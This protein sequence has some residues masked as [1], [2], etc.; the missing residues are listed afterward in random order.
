MD[1]LVLVQV[2]HNYIKWRFGVELKRIGRP[3][4]EV[5]LPVEFRQEGEGVSLPMTT[6]RPGRLLGHLVSQS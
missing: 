2:G 6:E 3:F 4:L 1:F 5:L